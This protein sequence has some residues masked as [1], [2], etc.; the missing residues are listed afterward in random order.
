MNQPSGAQ[1]TRVTVNR[2]NVVSDVIDGEAVIINL[3]TGKYFSL[4]ESGAEIWTALSEG[5]S[6]PELVELVRRSYEGDW[7]VM[8]RDVVALVS[9]LQRE[10]LVVAGTDSIDGAA[11]E[12]LREQTAVGDRPYVPPRL[13]IFTDM[14]DFLLVDPIHEVDER[15]L[16]H[17]S[18]GDGSAA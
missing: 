6:V 18:A 12:Q 10:G 17:P 9:E 8:V 15:G 13:E 2:A 4:R 14:Q 7:H 11:L 3:E 1:A 5:A 16:P